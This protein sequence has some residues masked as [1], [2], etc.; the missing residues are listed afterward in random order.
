MK[1]HI[2]AAHCLKK[3]PASWDLT[4]VRIGEWDTD[5]YIDCEDDDESHCAPPFEE[6][7]ISEKSVHPN[8]RRVSR[9]QHFDVALLRLAQK[10]TFHEYV[11]PICLPLDPLLWTKN[12]T[13]HSFD[14]A[15]YLIK[16][17]RVFLIQFFSSF[18]F[19]MG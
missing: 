13:D 1:F 19:R 12:Y 7:K 6:Y 9:S 10:V 17:F 16:L 11:Q 3:I 8:Y 4:G 18:V 15:G 2:K 5:S 14:V